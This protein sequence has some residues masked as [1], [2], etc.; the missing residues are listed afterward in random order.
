MHKEMLRSGANHVAVVFHP[1]RR[2]H[3]AL[4]IDKEYTKDG[5]RF[6]KDTAGKDHV[7]DTYDQIFGK[8]DT[9]KIVPR[10]KQSF[11]RTF[12]PRHK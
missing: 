5:I 4:T 11:Q 2:L 9:K 1:N 6:Y 8:R 3:I 10:P 7:A 12:K